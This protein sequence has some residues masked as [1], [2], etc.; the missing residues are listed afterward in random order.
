NITCGSAISCNLSIACPNVGD[1][2]PTI[3]P[4]P[5]DFLKDFLKER[6][7][8][9]DLMELAGVIDPSE[10]EMVIERLPD[11]MKKPLQKMFRKFE[12]SNSR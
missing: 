11:N 8:V 1:M 2:C 9:E 10:I 3:N 5:D 12:R 6:W 7:G 4:R